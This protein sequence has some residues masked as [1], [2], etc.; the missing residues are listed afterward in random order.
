M[1]DFAVPRTTDARNAD[2]VVRVVAMRRGPTV[3]WWGMAMLV[4][5]ESMLFGLMTATYY[6]LRF[7]NLHW[8]PAGIPEP[9]L[10]VPL[11]LLGVLLATS[12]PIQLAARAGSAGRVALTRA[13]LLLALVVQAGYFAM[14]VHLYR[15]DLHHFAPDTHAYGSIY[16]TLFGADHAHVALGL[17]LDVWLLWKLAH[18]LT[19][20]RLNALS[21]VAFYWH[22]VNV[23]TLVVTLTILSPSL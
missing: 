10:A 7:K 8:P 2:E 12:V 15:D 6:Y 11:V 4:A 13:L 16:F 22:A 3:A 17:L 5:S 18:G 23:I 21:A 19:T 14:Q 20:Y 1:T 9:K